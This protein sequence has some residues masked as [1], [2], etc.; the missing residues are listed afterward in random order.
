MED[1]EVEEIKD[2]LNRSIYR[3]LSA[4]N[5]AVESGLFFDKT[6]R[7]RAPTRKTHI[8]TRGR[9]DLAAEVNRYAT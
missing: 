5:E 8:R 1:V 9:Y 2:W 3:M 7:P 6:F 4:E